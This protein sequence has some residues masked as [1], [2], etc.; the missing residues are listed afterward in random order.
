MFPVPPLKNDLFFRALNHQPVPRVPVWMMRQAGRS[1]PE[2]NAYK[3]K[4]GL[5]LHQLFRSPEHAAE[6]SLLPRRFGVDAI[7]FFQDI[8][9]PLEP[10]GADFH[11][12]PG[13][14]LAAPLR[15][16]DQVQNLTT[17]DPAEGLPFVA[18]TLA[19]V[20]RR[21][22]GELPLLGFAGAPF[23][24][25][26]FLIEGGSPMKGMPHTL[27]FAA[28]QPR[29]FMQLLDKLAEV[30][31]LYLNHQLASGAHAVQLFESAGDLIP[32]ELYKRYAQPIHQAILESVRG[33]SI[34]FVKDS[35]F[36]DLMAQTPAAVLSLGHQVNLKDMLA[37]G[38]GRYAVQGNVSN[39]LL[40][41]GT[42]DQVAQAVANCIRSTGGRGHILNLDHG[43]KAET[44]FQNVLAFV[45]AAKNTPLGA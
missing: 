1:D 32:E 40:A 44:P 22:A 13:P 3:E 11:F 43:L 30:T 8:L 35:P 18:Q 12:V 28:E 23:T 21:L 37:R 31:T 10:M 38:Q 33:P 26:A 41:T 27:A 20:N 6:I 4:S 16:V 36:P 45:Q 15:H 5:T 14:K 34:L 2:Y 7:I 19:E 29:A 42:P 25:A 9:T 17:F 24:L 39:Q